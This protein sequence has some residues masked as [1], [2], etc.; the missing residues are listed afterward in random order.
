M[1]A[2]STVTVTVALNGYVETESLLY[3]QLISPP[4]ITSVLPSRFVSGQQSSVLISGSNFFKYSMNPLCAY[5]SGN[6]TFGNVSATVISDSLA[7][8]EVP[9]H[10]PVR[11]QVQH[12][13]AI[14]PNPVSEVQ[15]L[16]IS[17]LPNQQEVQV[18]KTTAWGLS[19]AV[20]ELRAGKSFVKETR[21]K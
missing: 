11:R 12:I 8:C 15:C 16:E 20:W 4:E 7:S 17:A 1:L 5:F 10:L 2:P 3:L 19:N 21:R 14:S 13:K 6:E 9:A 18:I